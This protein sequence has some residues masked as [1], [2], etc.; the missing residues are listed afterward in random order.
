MG[1]VNALK[2]YTLSPLPR[3]APA[4]ASFAG[5]ALEAWVLQVAGNAMNAPSCA[6]Q[7]L[8][9]NMPQNLIMQKTGD[10]KR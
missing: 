8:L 10:T 3:G 1:G 9:H 2:M 4:D 5:R 6:H 7:L